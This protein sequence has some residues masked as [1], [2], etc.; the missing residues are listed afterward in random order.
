MAPNAGSFSNY[1]SFVAAE[2]SE[3]DV[4]AWEVQLVLEYCD[5]GSLRE[6]LDQGLFDLEGEGGGWGRGHK[7][8]GRGGI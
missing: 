8:E 5:L 7:G 1:S 6:E 4:A 3:R 2:A